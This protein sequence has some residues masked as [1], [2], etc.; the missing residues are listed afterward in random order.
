[1][2][3][4][5]GLRKLLPANLANR[6]YTYPFYL[7]HNLISPMKK[8]SVLFSLSVFCLFFTGAA[9]AQEISAEFPFESKYLTVLN[10]KMHYV[11]EYADPS[12]PEQTTFLFLHGNPTSNYLWRNIIPYVKGHG[13]A[14]AP[15]LIGMGKSDKPSVDYTFQDHIRY[16]DG[17]IEQKKLKNVVLVIHDWGSALGFHYAARNEGNIKGIVFM[18][19][20]TRPM[21]W[22]DAGLMEKMLFK[23]MRNEKKGHKM[24]AENN[25]FIKT[26][27]FKM[28]TGRKLSQQEKNYYN[29]PY[30]TVESRKPIE[31]WPKEIPIDGSPARNFE[32]VNHY[33]QWLRSTTIPMLLLHANPGMIIKKRE[34]KRI[35]QEF[36]NIEIVMTGKGRHY[37]QE[38]HPHEIGQAVNNWFKRIK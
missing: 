20:I 23:R 6:I 14:V 9:A 12:D 11:E 25:F 5:S 2:S 28:G 17:F 35:R 15:D 38:D 36:K 18:E 24:I 31:T 22:K 21:E 32:I 37:I 13:R 7:K 34:V 10:S 16:L 27:L 19:A 4:L 8:L 1:M 30:P 33:A 29:S 26:I 3:E